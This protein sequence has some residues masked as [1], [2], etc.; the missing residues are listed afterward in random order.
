MIRKIRK[1]DGKVTD[2]NPVRIT[3]AIWKASN[4]LGNKDLIKSQDITEVVVSKLQE[5]TR[6]GDIPEVEQVQDLV[7]QALM[8]AGEY[9]TAKAYILYRKQHEDMRKIGGLLQEIELVD[10]YLGKA[11][12]RVKEN[13]NMDYSLQGLN[14]YSS[15]SIISNYWLR[16]IYPPEIST[17]HRS[18]DIHIHDL[19][20]LGPYCV[21]WDLR[22]ILVKG[23]RG[24]AGK[25]E[26]GPANHFG[27][28]LMQLVN[29]LYTLQGESAGAQA[30][31]NFDTLLAPFV[32]HD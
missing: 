10:N 6:F 25:I 30:V 16:K 17:A 2:F 3:N 28:A 32:R 29:F 1:R 5:I 7:E 15:E 22:E 13:S 9:D 24:A 31:S 19:G 23:F 26:S 12:W 20:T 11:D 14:V 8:E 4:A 18:G 27:V 21:G